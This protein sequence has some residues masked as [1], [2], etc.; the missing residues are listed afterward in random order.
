[1]AGFR[2]MK[3]VPVSCIAPGH[4]DYADL[5]QIRDEIVKQIGS[6]ESVRARFPLLVRDAVDFVLDPVRTART[7]LKELDN[8]EKTFIGL[9][10][11]HFVRDMLDVPKGLRDLV[12]GGRDVDIKNTVG[13]NWS[14]PQE[15]YRGSEPCL[16]MAVDEAK[17]T[18]FLGVILAKPEYLHGGKGNRDTKKGVSSAGFFNILW[19]LRDEPFPASK[20]KGLDMDRFRELRKTL[21]GS[22]RAAQFCREN[23]GR[24]IHRDVAQALLYP[25]QDYMKRLRA[26]GGAPDF[27]KFESIAILIGTFKK[28][29]VLADQL[30]FPRLK[31]DEIVAVEPRSPAERTLLKRA[32]LIV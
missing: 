5:T 32:D 10:L 20:F 9:K 26:N 22:E 27:L 7:G 30:G 19:L 28:D 17:H 1:M 23:I 2:A 16:L 21:A 3:V 13:D 25:Q 11:E 4:I 14:I 12:I 24:V 18:C 29:R 8:V 31:A 15:T 6:L